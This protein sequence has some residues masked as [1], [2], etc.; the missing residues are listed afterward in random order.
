MKKTLVI[1]LVLSLLLGMFTGCAGN[2]P[3]I[4]DDETTPPAVSAETTAAQSEE[5]TEEVTLSEWE[6]AHL[7]IITPEQKYA[8]EKVYWEGTID[9]DFD[10]NV[11]LITIGYPYNNREYTVEDFAEIGC[12]D[13]IDIWTEKG[14]N[15]WLIQKLV[16]N[17][18]S[19]QNVLDSIKWLEAQPFI[20]SA[21]PNGYFQAD[22]C[23]TPNDPYYSNNYQW[24]IDQIELPDA[25][26]ITTGS[27]NITV[28]V[29]DSGIR[30]NHYDLRNRVDSNLSKS[31]VSDN[32][33]D[34]TGLED[35]LGHGTNV[36]G[37]IGAIT[38][39]A[40][41][42]AGVCWNVTLVSLRVTVNGTDFNPTAIASAINYAKDNDIDIINCSMS[43]TVNYNTIRLAIQNYSGLLVCSAGND[44]ESSDSNYIYPARYNFD[45]II[46]V[47]ASDSSDAKAT[48]S[49]YG[50]ATVDLFAPGVNIY[51]TAIDPDAPLNINYYKSVSGTSFSAPLVA[52]VAALILSVYPN[53]QPYDL[54]VSICDNVDVCSGLSGYCLTGGRLNAAAALENAHTHTHVYEYR[55]G[56][57][58][59]ETD[60][61]ETCVHC[62]VT[63][64]V[65]HSLSYNNEDSSEHLCFCTVCYI[66]FAES[67]TFSSAYSYN[68]SQHYKA[69][70]CGRQIDAANHTLTYTNI[71]MSIHSKQCDICGYYAT[72]DHSW[73]LETFGVDPV[74]ELETIVFDPGELAEPE[75]RIR[76]R[77]YKCN[78][79]SPY[80]PAPFAVDPE[81]E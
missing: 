14:T 44:N 53:Y 70:V 7:A 34:N 24:A 50:A 33:T 30:A 20:H 41:G 65:D 42:I 37:V 23:E 26:D 8:N 46:V 78:A 52:G 16:L 27:S 6:K 11:V 62:G 71:D 4:P 29:M 35:T 39:N 15:I 10:D 28:A 38:N 3:P 12:I 68:S 2:N 36:A 67:H 76:Y 60:H 48:F 18:N 72:E 45:N 59:T 43:W 81:S 9:D 74:E 47:G 31:F 64:V 49:N 73:S 69:C 57:A 40:T 19:K 61:T 80:N 79:L 54:Y 77:C 21:E 66:E 25:W 75:Y 32:Q 58:R 51:T 13:L 17:Q 63:R 56:N 5:P 1:F 55:Y 22:L